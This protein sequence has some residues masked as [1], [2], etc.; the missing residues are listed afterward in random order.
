MA[1]GTL[2]WSSKTKEQTAEALVI[3]GATCFCNRMLDKWQ[4]M[5]LVLGLW[6]LCL[7][8]GWSWCWLEA[9]ATR[10]N[11]MLEQR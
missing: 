6:P 10:A 1:L 3:Y 9:P 2:G 4:P 5:R 7:K 8:L 11:S